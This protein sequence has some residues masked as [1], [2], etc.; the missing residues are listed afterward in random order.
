VRTVELGMT[1]TDA[2][3][4]GEVTVVFCNLLDDGRICSLKRLLCN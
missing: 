4:D 1:I 2:A 3:V